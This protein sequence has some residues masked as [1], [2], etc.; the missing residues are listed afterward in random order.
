MGTKEI[1]NR[2]YAYKDES[3]DKRLN[4]LIDDAIKLILD[5]IIELKGE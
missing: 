1:I 5:L 2:L 3:N 4:D